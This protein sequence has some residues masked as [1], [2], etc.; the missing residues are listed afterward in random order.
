MNPTRTL[1]GPKPARYVP[2]H[3]TDIRVTF[4]KFRRLIALQAV[5]EK[6]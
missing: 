6:K 5:K 3:Q 1:I 4:A 2:A